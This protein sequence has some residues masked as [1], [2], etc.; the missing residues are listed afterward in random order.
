MATATGIHRSTPKSPRLSIPYAVITRSMAR[1]RL[2]KIVRLRPA[3]CPFSGEA[4]STRSRPMIHIS[5]VSIRAF[6]RSRAPSRAAPSDMTVQH[7]PEEFHAGVQKG[8]GEAPRH[9]LRRTGR[10]HDEQYAVKGAPEVG[11]SEYL[12]YDGGVEQD[13]VPVLSESP[14]GPRELRGARET[15]W[16]RQDRACRDDPEVG[17]RVEAV[18]V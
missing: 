12:A 14:D 13:H 9:A 7:H 16:T 15:P 11:G 1:T 17:R 5:P 6:D 2:L 3:V 18:V 4:F 10:V 8:V